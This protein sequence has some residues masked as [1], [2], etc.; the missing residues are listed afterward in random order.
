ML[1]GSI[2][3]STEHGYYPPVVNAILK[4]LQGQPLDQL[5][6]GR[7]QIPFL[8][9]DKAWFVILEYQTESEST[10]KPEV[11]HH[12]SDLQIVLSGREQMAWC[13]DDGSFSDDGD[14][15]QQR[16]LQYYQ[17]QGMRLN[18]FSA[19]EGYFYLFTPNTV[20][21]TNISDQELSAV[22]K[23]VVKIHNDLL[24]AR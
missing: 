18:Y 6:T 12:H 9:P 21:F 3:S 16:D 19:E 22:R 11:H 24:V 23:L 2:Q 7:H 10:F 20:H 4:Y 1:V 13:M 14:Y 15:L 17:R 5:D 8:P